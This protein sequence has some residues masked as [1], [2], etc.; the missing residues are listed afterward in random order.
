MALE[1]EQTGEKAASG[2]RRYLPLVI[3]VAAAVAAYMAGLHN[4][5][6]LNTVAENREYLTNA[7]A[8]NL[9]LA[10]LVYAT[11]YAISTALSLPGGALL[12]IVGGFLF[13]WLI[14]GIATIISATIGATIVFL[15]AKSSLG[16][17][18]TQKA[19]PFA[20]KLA[21]GFN[22]DAFNYLMFLR[23]VPVFPFWLINIAPALFDV[24]LRTYVITT[25][26]GIIP[27][28]MAIAILGA[29]LGSV[30]DRQQAL[31]EACIAAKGI[32]NCSFNIELGALLTPELLAA[33]VA[34]GIVSLIPVAFKRWKAHTAGKTSL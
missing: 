34:L 4:Y 23:L 27:G 19:G 6:S 22:T 28:T 26:F 2:I 10:L 20:R 33:F 30:I 14:G 25:F 3:L 9:W 29:G 21:D 7:V 31:Q 12:T 1:N 5:I 13:G 24:R 8:T 16:N 18:L 32:E 17:F 15:V 11:V